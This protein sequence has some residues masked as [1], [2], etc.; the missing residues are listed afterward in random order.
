MRIFRRRPVAP[1]APPEAAAPEPTLWDLVVAFR[2]QSAREAQQ[3]PSVD[4]AQER[5]HR[6]QEARNRAATERI[7]RAVARTGSWFP[8]D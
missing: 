5:D 2:Q 7:A 8:G 6:E 1:P 4:A 3:A